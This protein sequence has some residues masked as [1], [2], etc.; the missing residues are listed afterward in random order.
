MA[1][2]KPKKGYVYLLQSASDSSLF[3]YGCTTLTPECRCKKVNSDRKGDNFEVIACFKSFDIFKDEKNIK[4]KM[5][6]W[7]AGYLGEVFNIGDFEEFKSG[8]DIM[9]K[10]LITGGVIK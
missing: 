4:E 10:F 3:K 8:A 1:V 5:L 6:P 9:M 2:R 7:G